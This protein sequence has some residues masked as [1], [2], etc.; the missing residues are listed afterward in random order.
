MLRQYV[1]ALLKEEGDHAGYT[2]HDIMQAGMDMNPYG[3]HYGSNDALYNAF[4]KPFVDVAQTAAG[5]AKEMSQRTQTLAKVAFES[6]ATSVIP[7]LRDDYK[8]IFDNEKKAIQKIR[9]EYSEVYKSNWDALLNDDVMAVAFFYNPTAF[10]T[11]QLARKAPNILL[12]LTSI[13]TGGEIDNWVE[14]V[15]SKVKGGSEKKAHSGRK[16]TFH[17]FGKY[18]K[19]TKTRLPTG[20]PGF[21]VDYYGEGALHEDGE[22]APDVAGLLTSEKLKSRIEQSPMVQKMQA[23]ARGVVRGTLEQVFKQARGVM[24]VKTLQD[25]QNKTGA[26]L[27]GLEKLQQASPQER[28]GIER[29][30]LETTKKSMKEFYVQ[31]LE[32]QVKKAIEAGVPEDSP[33]VQDY[34]RVISKIKTL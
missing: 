1:R 11:V 9:Q 14:K 25:L 30:I 16:E 21:G 4:I 33:Y 17:P 2:A 32:G 12:N 20:G 28:Q 10:F 19:G 18:K 34:A 24:S 29:Q 23:A 22:K 15:R 26:K 3:M 8:E 31:N 5:K 6:I 13:L 7:I 27:K